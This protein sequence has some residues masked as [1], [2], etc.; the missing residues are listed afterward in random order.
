[1]EYNYFFLFWELKIYKF[2]NYSR[3]H[4]NNQGYE[5][6]YIFSYN[7]MPDKKC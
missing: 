6:I 3:F 7:I 2:I 1:M 4:K 5:K